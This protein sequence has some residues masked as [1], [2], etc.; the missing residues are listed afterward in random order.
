M[1]Q[2]EKEGSIDEL[3]KALHSWFLQKWAMR[4]PDSGP[5]LT[6]KAKI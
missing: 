6:V 1:L 4:M 2:D 3:D 5:I